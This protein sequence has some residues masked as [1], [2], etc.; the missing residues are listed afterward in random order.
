MP[1]FQWTVF[2][3]VW[4]VY[5][6]QLKYIHPRAKNCKAT[7]KHLRHLFYP[8]HMHRGDSPLTHRHSHWAIA[9]QKVQTKLGNPVFPLFVGVRPECIYYTT[10]WLWSVS[11][12]TLTICIVSP[13]H[14]P[15]VHISH[16][17]RR[18]TTSWRQ[19]PDPHWAP[20][21]IWK[22]GWWHGN[23]MIY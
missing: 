3:F 6:I 12:C 4:F 11:S 8:L 2:I 15:P 10:T 1:R 17:V 22:K 20:G 13:S 14:A 5:N 9:S 21:E 18:V 23:G 19:T 16:P 7:A